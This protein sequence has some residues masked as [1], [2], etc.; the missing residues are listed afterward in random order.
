MRFQ[1]SLRY[2][3]VDSPRRRSA[4]VRALKKERDS[5]PLFADQI[6]AEQPDVDT[7]MNARRIA[8]IKKEK[9]SR[10]LCADKWREG[11]RRMMQYPEPVRKKLMD[12]W[13]NHRWLPGTYVYFLDMMHM[14]DTGTLNLPE[15]D[16]S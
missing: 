15:T 14:Y 8:W 13:N 2:D 7:V 4:V 11:R 6:A 1:K 16:T 5:Y 10:Q 9:H 12:Y 3:F